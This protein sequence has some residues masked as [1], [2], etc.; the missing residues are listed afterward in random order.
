MVDPEAETIKVYR[1]DEGGYGRPN[2]LVRERGD[3]VASPLLGDL[4]L[5]LDRVFR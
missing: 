2:L 5:T 4:R 1:N 3:T